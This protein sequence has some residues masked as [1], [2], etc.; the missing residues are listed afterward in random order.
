VLNALTIDVEDYYQ[1]SA[2]ASVVRFENW[3]SYESRVVRNTRR[4]LDILDEYGVKAT[5]FVL[6]WEAEQR[7]GM[8]E[9]ILKRGHEIGS[10]GYCHRLI[11]AMSPAECREDIGRSKAC[12]E[13]ITGTAINGFRAASYSIVTR[14]LWCLDILIDL[15]FEYDSSI[16]PIRHDRYGIPGAER[17][18]HVIQ[19]PRGSIVEFPLSTA[20][21]FGLRI[22]VAGGGYLRFLPSRLIQRGIRRINDLE[23]QAAIVYLHPWEIDPDQPRLPGPL[24]SRLR[25]YTNLGGTEQK[26]RRL[27]E[28]F[29]FG[30][31]R[32]VLRAWNVTPEVRADAY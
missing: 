29:A 13:R 25:H 26:F 4:L 16:F 28:Q 32:E 24:P 9:E 18:L 19:R 2:F 15:G 30:P 22:P 7:P 17:F 12:L 20:R 14:S 11:Y 5:F 21:M 6:G 31:V 8:V 27:L 23:R 10:H 3:P 1:V